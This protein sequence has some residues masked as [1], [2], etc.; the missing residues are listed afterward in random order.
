MVYDE[1]TEDEID[2]IWRRDDKDP[3]EPVRLKWKYVRE[4]AKRVC[5]FIN[6]H[7]DFIHIMSFGEFEKVMKN[8]MRVIKESRNVEQK[9]RKTTR[10]KRHDETETRTQKAKALVADIKHE[11]MKREDIERR[12]EEIFGQGSRQELEGVLAIEKIV[13]RIEQMSK[14]SP[15]RQMGEDSARF[16]EETTGGPKAESLLEAEQDLPRQLWRR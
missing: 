2:E 11:K 8:V 10:Q 15:I 12:L 5:D 1:I 14:R 4:T 13:E 16:Q 7:E 6:A 3:E 9:R